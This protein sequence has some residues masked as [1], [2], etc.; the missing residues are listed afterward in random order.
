[1]SKSPGGRIRTPHCVRGRKLSRHLTLPEAYD[2]TGPTYGRAG[3]C[4]VSTADKI[5]FSVPIFGILILSSLTRI[6]CHYE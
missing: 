5:C 6:V 3:E 1:M 2:L 4:R